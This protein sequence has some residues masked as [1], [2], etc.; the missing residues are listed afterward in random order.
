MGELIMIKNV[1][2]FEIII[3]YL[4]CMYPDSKIKKNICGFIIL[5]QQ[6]EQNLFHFFSFAEYIFDKNK[7]YKKEV[8]L[9]RIDKLKTI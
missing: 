8:I 7:S 6:M 2:D 4:L 5:P 9:F 1:L 3:D